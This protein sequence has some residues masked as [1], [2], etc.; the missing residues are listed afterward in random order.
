MSL[1]EAVDE[2]NQAVDDWVAGKDS[3][4]LFKAGEKLARENLT[5]ILAENKMDLLKFFEYA[6]LPAKLQ[7]VS[8]MFYNLAHWIVENCPQNAERT[9]ALRKLLESKDCAVRTLL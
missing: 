2:W 7:D 4:R 5:F 3:N 8:R 1:T 9:V 6:H